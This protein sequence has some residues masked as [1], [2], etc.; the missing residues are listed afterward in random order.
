MPYDTVDKLPAVVKKYSPKVKRQWMHVFNSTWKKL[1][2]EGIIDKSRE[3][4][5]FKAANST[6]KKR[7]TNPEKTSRPDYFNHLIDTWLGNL[8]G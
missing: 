7:M 1:T 5:S 2:K 3:T 8:E 6:L 4:R